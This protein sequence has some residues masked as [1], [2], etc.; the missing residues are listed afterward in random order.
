MDL[1]TRTI[2][3]YMFAISWYHNLLTIVTIIIIIIIIITNIIYYKAN[4]G[5]VSIDTSKNMFRTCF[6]INQDTKTITTITP[7]LDLFLNN[8]N[9]GTNGYVPILHCNNMGSNNYYYG[10]QHHCC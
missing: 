4:P 6:R 1:Y 3:N 7:D 2:N 8:T 10:N 9:T 5:L